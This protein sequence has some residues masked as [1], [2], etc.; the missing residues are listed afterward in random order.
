MCSQSHVFKNYP[1]TIRGIKPV[2][3]AKTGS[4]GWFSVTGRSEEELLNRAL[5]CNY[6]TCKKICKIT[7]VRC[8]HSKKFT[9]YLFTVLLR[10]CERSVACVS[11]VSCWQQQTGYQRREEWKVNYYMNSR[12][13]GLF[14]RFWALI[15]SEFFDLTQANFEANSADFLHI[16]TVVSY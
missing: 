15:L 5:F 14:F 7:G 13:P 10:I 1:T 6:R 4:G 9:N 3:H 16:T 12:F 8:Y 2:S 11:C